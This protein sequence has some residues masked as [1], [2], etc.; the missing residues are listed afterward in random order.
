MTE[1]EYVNLKVL[2]TKLMVAPRTVR[3]WISDP[4]LKFPA[5]R[6][7]GKLL[8]NWA[9][10]KQWLKGHRVAVVD[11]DAMADEILNRLGKGKNN[12]T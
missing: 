1:S 10:V 9:E 12:E 11:V 2:S 6:V 5:Y 3:N 8:F 7:K 4:T